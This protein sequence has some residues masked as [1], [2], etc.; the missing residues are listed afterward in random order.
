MP[1]ICQGHAVY[2]TNWPSKAVLAALPVSAASVGFAS[3]EETGI[4]PQYYTGCLEAL[5]SELQ[6]SSPRLCPL[7]NISVYV[8]VLLV[9]YTFELVPDYSI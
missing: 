9:V 1:R 7:E 2:Q 4:V 8:A 6:G 5:H 3:W